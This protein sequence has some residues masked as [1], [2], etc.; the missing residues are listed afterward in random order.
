[1]SLRDNTW[2]LSRACRE[3]RGYRVRKTKEKERWSDAFEENLPQANFTCWNI[4]PYKLV[5][6]SGCMLVRD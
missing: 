2:E 5:V 3:L 6:V 4:D 1:M